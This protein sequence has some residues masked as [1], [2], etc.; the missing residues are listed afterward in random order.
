MW[1]FPL[2]IVVRI[3]SGKYLSC[4]SVSLSFLCYFFS[5]INILFKLIITNKW[6]RSQGERGLS[7]VR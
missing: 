2:H 3:L 6:Y 7:F 4:L 5:A 1:I